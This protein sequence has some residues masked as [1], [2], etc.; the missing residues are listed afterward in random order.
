M[1]SFILFIPNSLFALGILENL[2]D[3]VEIRNYPNPM[4]GLTYDLYNTTQGSDTIM[5]QRELS[6]SSSSHH[7]PPSHDFLKKDLSLTFSSGNSGSVNN[8]YLVKT[9]GTDKLYYNIYD[10][11]TDYHILKDHAHYS[12]P[13]DVLVYN[14]KKIRV[15]NGKSKTQEKTQS[16]YIEILDGQYVPSGSYSDTI[17]IDI[18][19]E[20][21]I[22]ALLEAPI[23]SKTMTITV[24]V[25]D[26]LGLCIV[27]VGG[28]YDPDS[29]T[30]YA[31]DFGTL[32]EGKSISAQAVALA[33]TRYTISVSSTNGGKMKHESVDEYVPYTLFFNGDPITIGTTATQLIVN[34]PPSS[35]SGT[36]HDLTV[37]I[38]TLSWLPSGD[39]ADNLIFEIT[40]N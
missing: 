5:V 28:A 20:A 12:G 9:G 6:Y 22:L 7:S 36:A 1:I 40:S 29:T 19:D 31:M 37:T 30:P 11:F 33:N 3:N 39:Y 32:E 13:D 21:G 14:F 4:T 38:G 8:R 2:E 15:K 26:T 23:D 34:A 18:Y 27:D 35:I 16:F 25:S 24:E 10:N 17:K